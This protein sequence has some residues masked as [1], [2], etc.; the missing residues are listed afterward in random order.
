MMTASHCFDEVDR[1][2]NTVVLFDYYSKEKSSWTTQETRRCKKVLSATKPTD[3]DF[4]DPDAFSDY[5][6]FEIDEPI[7]NR[8]PLKLATSQAPFVDQEV[9]TIGHP[10]GRAMKIADQAKIFHVINK[11][12]VT[13][14]DGFHGNSGSPI[15]DARTH[16]VI[17]IYS[18][19]DEDDHEQVKQDGFQR[20]ST[21]I[22]TDQTYAETPTYGEH[23]SQ[24][25]LI[26]PIIQS[27]F[28][29]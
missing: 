29:M 6:L 20:Q 2:E 18:S 13:N 1:C 16:E 12:I 9:Y 15:L 5:V 8:V 3:I 4:T 11:N 26:W 21:R 24:M 17:A 27:F 10:R 25:I 7:F 22:I 23:A 28:E 14:L 19:G